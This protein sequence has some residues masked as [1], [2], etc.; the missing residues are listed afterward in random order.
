MTATTCSSCGLRQYPLATGLCRRCRGPLGFSFLEISLRNRA[1][2]ARPDAKQL[3]IGS[4]LRALRHRQGKSQARIARRAGTDRTYISRL[5]C[6]DA[7]PN[8]S[9]LLRLLEALNVE[10]LYLRLGDK[11][12]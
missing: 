3:A 1:A 10:S 2:S 12:P 4:V 8:L 9:T 6:G 11:A 7:L 5:E